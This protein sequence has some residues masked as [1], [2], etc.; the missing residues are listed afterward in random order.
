MSESTKTAETGRKASDNGS[1]A[2]HATTEAASKA[3]KD[4]V[5]ETAKAAE[6][7]A[8]HA[9]E[10]AHQVGDRIKES[11]NVAT[12][13]SA[14][15]VEQGRDVILFAARAAAGVG[16]RAA[17]IGI[18]QSHKVISSTVQ[19]LDVYRD[20]SERSAERVQALFASYLSW[21]RGLQQIQ[22]AWLEIIDQGL[23]SAAQKP[24]EILRSKTLVEF[25][26]A[27]RE[28]YLGTIN[29]A[30]ESSSRLLEL[31]SRAAQDAVRPLQNGR[32]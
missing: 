8:D 16:G 29:H 9:K 19:A 2:S 30:V 32:H 13:V 5:E 15:V 17:D 10:A 27:Q 31:A 25:A 7:G 14:K 24:H 4:T 6:T 26:E 12:T 22:H 20:A 1:R 28:L 18:G 11:A 23:E 21:G 3:T